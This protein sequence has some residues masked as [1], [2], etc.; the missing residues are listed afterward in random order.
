RMLRAVR[1]A[2]KLGFTIDPPTAEPI[3]RLAPLLAEASPARLFEEMLKL[4]LS[5]HAVAS[6]EGLERHGLLAALMPRPPPRC[7]PTAAARCVAWSCRDWLVPTP[8][9]PRTSRCPRRS[10]SRCCCGPPIAEPWPD[11]RRRACSW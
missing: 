8:G 1:L 7:V 3:P 11:C 2:A 9:L 6:F 4:F 5:G 10:C